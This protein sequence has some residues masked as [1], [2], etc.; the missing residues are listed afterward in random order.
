MPSQLTFKALREANMKRV[1]MF[2]EVRSDGG[3]T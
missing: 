2:K 3:D 1:T